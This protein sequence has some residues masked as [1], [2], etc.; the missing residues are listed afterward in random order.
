MASKSLMK[1]PFRDLVW[2]EAIALTG[3]RIFLLFLLSNLHLFS[4]S[5]ISALENSVR[6]VEILPSL[7]RF[8]M[9][10]FLGVKGKCRKERNRALSPAYCG[11][12]HVVEY[13]GGFCWSAGNTAG[14]GAGR[15]QLFGKL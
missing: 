2:V 15:Y 9:E 1:I 7:I 3:K 5:K 8:F 10:G 4:D 14:Q 6:M 12:C 11:W 13:P